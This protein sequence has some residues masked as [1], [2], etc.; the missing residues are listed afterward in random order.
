MSICI[1]WNDSQPAW[2]RLFTTSSSLLKSKIP[3]FGGMFATS[4][5]ARTR[6][7]AY[8]LVIGRRFLIMRSVALPYLVEDGQPCC[9]REP[10]HH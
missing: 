4:V 2:E 8:S 3:S 6:N 7:V 10:S 1:C 5:A 9:R